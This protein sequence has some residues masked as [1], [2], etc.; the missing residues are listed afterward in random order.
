MVINTEISTEKIINYCLYGI[1]TEINEYIVVY[2]KMRFLQGIIRS[3]LFKG[4]FQLF[5][6]NTKIFGNVFLFLMS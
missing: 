6:L 3:K 5:Q 4:L 2:Q 1:L